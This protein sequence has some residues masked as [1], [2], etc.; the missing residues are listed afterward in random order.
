MRRMST[1]ARSAAA[2][3]RPDLGHTPRDR[4]RLAPVSQPAKPVSTKPIDPILAADLRR[5]RSRD[6]TDLIVSRAEWLAPE[7]R[8]LILAVYRDGSTA[9]DI[10]RLS[11]QSPRTVRRRLRALVRRALSSLFEYVLRHRDDWSPTR[12]RVATACVLQ[13]R[14]LRE[15]SK[16]L[17]L[18]LHTVRR[19]MEAVRALHEASE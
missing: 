9:E 16:F 19:Q 14:T 4:F 3:P 12:R 1:S 5:R 6:L 11:G 15:A 8:A 2:M 18:S 7:D 13:G 10:A 17:R